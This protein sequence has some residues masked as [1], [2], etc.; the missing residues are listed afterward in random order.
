MASAVAVEGGARSRRVERA[1]RRA[2]PATINTAFLFSQGKKSKRSRE[3]P[4]VQTR[5]R[6]SPSLAAPV[7]KPRRTVNRHMEAADREE[8]RLRFHQQMELDTLRKI[9]DRIDANGCHAAHEAWR[10]PSPA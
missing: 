10:P 7:L 8:K 6:L 5:C 9:F 1:K 4:L 3:T 2:E